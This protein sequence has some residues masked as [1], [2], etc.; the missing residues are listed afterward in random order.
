MPLIECVTEVDLS[1]AEETVEFLTK[2]RQTLIFADVANCKMEQ[3]GMRCDVNL[4]VK[5][6]GSSELGTKVEMKNLNSFKSV[7]GAIKY[8][9][10]RQIEELEKGGK[11]VQETRKWDETKEVTTSMRKKEESKDYRYM[12]EPD[13]ISIN[14]SPKDIDKIRNTLPMMPEERFKKYTEEYGLPEQDANLLISEKDYSDYFD[15]CLK[16]FFEP[17]TVANWIMTDLLKLLTSLRFTA[18]PLPV[19]SQKR[20][21]Y[22][23]NTSTGIRSIFSTTSFPIFSCSIHSKNSISMALL[24]TINSRIGFFF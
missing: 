8:E 16:L 5:K 24:P 7:Y 2:L 15:N 17:K 9:M 19:S 21:A 14:I 10:N 11:I 12:P 1:S 18:P 20:K 13:F 3:A 6:H 4:S 23:S 22:S